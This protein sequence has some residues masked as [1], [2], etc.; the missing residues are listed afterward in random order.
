MMDL[1]RDEYGV[2]RHG[3]CRHVHVLVLCLLLHCDISYRQLDNSGATCCHEHSI[4]ALDMS[5]FKPL[6]HYSL[7]ETSK[8]GAS[9]R[10]G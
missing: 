2:A 4:V 5:E 1:R 10:K 9:S 7:R 6:T 3:T 8:H